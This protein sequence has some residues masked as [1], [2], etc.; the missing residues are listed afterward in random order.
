M[1]RVAVGLLLATMAMV[2]SGCVEVYRMKLIR[3]GQ[4]VSQHVGGQFVE[5]ADLSV[6]VQAPAFFIIGAGE[7][8]ACVTALEYVYQNSPPS[9]KSMVLAF[10]SLMNA[11]GHYLGSLLILIINALSSPIWIGEDPNQS[12]LEYYLFVLSIIGFINFFIY[13]SVS[14]HYLH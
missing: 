7:V 11:S 9:M 3:D 8:L 6:V 5:A 14:M 4:V 1:N 13:L 2:Y 12:H 10:N